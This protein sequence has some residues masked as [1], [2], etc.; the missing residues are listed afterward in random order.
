MAAS[1][2]PSAKRA[3]APSLL[4]LPLSM[5]GL[6]CVMTS[7]SQPLGGIGWNIWFAKVWHMSH[8]NVEKLCRF[9][10]SNNHWIIL[11]RY[12][13]IVTIQE[14]YRVFS[15]CFVFDPIRGLL[16]IIYCWVWRL[17][18]FVRRRRNPFAG[19]WSIP[20]CLQPLA[21]T[22]RC[23]MCHAKAR[24]CTAQTWNHIDRRVNLLNKYETNRL[25]KYCWSI[26]CHYTESI[27]S[28]HVL[29][30][31]KVTLFPAKFRCWSW[32]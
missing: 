11:I 19:G 24:C 26:W 12:W 16:P 21:G 4:V 2:R 23:E 6:Y 10:G 8:M 1:T 32:Y 25:I 5:F 13:K 7:G 30:I 27:R 17:W 15:M 9:G 29:T 20:F 22:V 28:Y 18:D 31:A 3:A 14:M